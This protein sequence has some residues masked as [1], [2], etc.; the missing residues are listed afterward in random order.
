MPNRIIE[1]GTPATFALR[2][3]P[4]E[5][6]SDKMLFRYVDAMH[7]LGEQDAFC[8]ELGGLTEEEFDLFKRISKA[9][10]EFTEQRFGQKA[11]PKGGLVRAFIAYRYIHLISPPETSTV[12]EIGP[13]SG[14]LGA[15]L[16]MA[17][18]RYAATDVTQAFYIFQSNLWGHLFGDRLVELAATKESLEGFE[19]LPPGTILHVPW[20]K[21]NSS[22]PE[23]IRLKIDVAT[24][25]HAMCEMQDTS[26]RYAL[27]LFHNCL[28]G[29]EGLKCF[30][31]E[32]PG[33][34]SMRTHQQMCEGFAAADYVS[35]FKE[36]PIDV[37][38]PANHGDALYEPSSVGDAP[39]H[40]LNSVEA[41]IQAGKA[42]MEKQ[43][44]VSFEEMRE[45]QSE[46]MDGADI[47]NDDEKF[48]RF[49]YNTDNWS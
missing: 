31:I 19:E 11:I 44:R 28:G 26:F 12:F 18:Y 32:G 2:G 45:F 46:L 7:E 1:A 20:W 39:P 33:L 49:A 48:L 35:V 9:V 22:T 38:A 23:N 17:G 30:F 3:Y 42:R 16:A 15:L 41:R 8:D 10:A 27:R 25:N 5:V 14:Y 13:G 29:P 40:R 24:A 47:L 21:F 43:K 34:D 4:T 36:F 37:F 6:H